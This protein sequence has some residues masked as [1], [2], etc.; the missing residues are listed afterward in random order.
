MTYFNNIH[1]TLLEL[2]TNLEVL[3][4]PRRAWLYCLARLGL[5]ALT[6]KENTLL[7]FGVNLKQNL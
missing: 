5:G 6:T 4:T 1:K 7:S 3:R 2:N